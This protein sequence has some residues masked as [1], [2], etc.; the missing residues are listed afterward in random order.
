MMGAYRATSYDRIRNG[1][2]VHLSETQIVDADDSRKLAFTVTERMPRRGFSIKMRIL[3]R[4]ET[5]TSTEAT[6]LGEFRPMGKNMSNQTAVHKAFLLV[7]NEVTMRYG[8]EGKG[9]MAGFVNAIHEFPEPINAASPPRNVVFSSSPVHESLFQQP[10]SPRQN[11]HRSMPSADSSITATSLNQMVGAEDLK[12]SFGPP[13]SLSPKESNHSMNQNT[14]RDNGGQNENKKASQD[15]TMSKEV[16]QQK[17]RS[18]RRSSSSR[19]KG[20]KDKDKWRDR[21]ATPSMLQINNHEHTRPKQTK[22]S[23]KEF[24]EMPGDEHGNSGMNRHSI[25]VKPL[26]KIR[27]SLMPAPREEDEENDSASSP[28]HSSKSK[29]KRHSKPSKSSSRKS[30]SRS[31]RREKMERI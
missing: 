3:L 25:E 21:P 5:D 1:E 12:L 11:R 19:D 27:L 26:P 16:S 4:P 10:R 31:S 20:K 13:T 24:A 30:S 18:S 14:L 23:S 8:T 22:I 7:L 28:V 29:K 15:H 2:V 17:E 6:I 9:L